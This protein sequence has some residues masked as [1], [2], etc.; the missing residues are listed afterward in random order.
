MKKLFV[1]GY[2][3]SRIFNGAEEKTPFGKDIDTYTL[4]EA[5]KLGFTGDGLREWYEDKV[6]KEFDEATESEKMKY[7]LEYTEDDELAG[8]LYF[9]EEEKAEEYKQD[10]IKEIEELEQEYE[11]AGKKQDEYGYFREVYEKINK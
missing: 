3:D 4:E 6:D 8:L 9:D 10:V 7:L 11:Y 2:Y 1:G 5:L